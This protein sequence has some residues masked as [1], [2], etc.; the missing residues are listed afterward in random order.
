MRHGT[1]PSDQASGEVVRSSGGGLMAASARPA[2]HRALSYSREIIALEKLE[3][4]FEW[5]ATREQ[6]V[7]MS[8]GPLG[9]PRSGQTRRVGPMARADSDSGRSPQALHRLDV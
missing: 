6:N 7:T 5:K 3:Q 1:V 4:S 2:A 8:L 9:V